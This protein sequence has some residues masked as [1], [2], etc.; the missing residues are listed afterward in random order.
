M[1]RNKPKPAIDSIKMFGASHPSIR[2][3]VKKLS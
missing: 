1:K 3:A 2:K